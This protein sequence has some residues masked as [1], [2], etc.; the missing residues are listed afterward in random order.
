[1]TR[2]G[3]RDPEPI[4]N[5]EALDGP[6]ADA[7]C[8]EPKGSAASTPPDRAGSAS[9]MSV[10][11][12]LSTTAPLTGENLDGPVG[13]IVQ[14]ILSGQRE[15]DVATAHELIKKTHRDKAIDL[16][17]ELVP[18]RALFKDAPALGLNNQVHGELKDGV[19]STLAARTFLRSFVYHAAE[20]YVDHGEARNT[21]VRELIDVAATDAGQLCSRERLGELMDMYKDTRVSPHASGPYIPFTHEHES[22]HDIE[23]KFVGLP[24]L[25][26][27]Y[28]TSGWTRFWTRSETSDRLENDP[29]RNVR[30]YLEGNYERIP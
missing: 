18:L 30:T 22:N 20:V 17:E 8:A 13:E 3:P 14:E 11:A 19:Q 28:L 4:Q 15:L 1:M 6:S 23:V 2:I 27:R 10:L 24:D 9:R 21:K 16:E 12:S 5:L 29:M 26:E 25:F 7:E